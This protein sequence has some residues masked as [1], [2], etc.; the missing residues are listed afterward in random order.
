MGRWRLSGNQESQKREGNGRNEGEK[1]EESERHGSD[2][3]VGDRVEVRR[4][5]MVVEDGPVDREGLL[6]DH[7]DLE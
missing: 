3:L 2:L 6:V 1:W 5:F 4:G 7:G